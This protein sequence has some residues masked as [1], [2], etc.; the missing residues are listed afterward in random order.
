MILSFGNKCKEKAADLSGKGT[1]NLCEILD[2][3]EK[4]MKLLY[5]KIYDNSI[6]S[7][8]DKEQTK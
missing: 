3:I 1:R 8:N 2:D 4:E 5:Q 6:S 7:D